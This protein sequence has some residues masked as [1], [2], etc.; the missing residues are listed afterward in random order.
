MTIK[1]NCLLTW[2]LEE[3]KDKNRNEERYRAN[4]KIY[5]ECINQINSLGYSEVPDERYDELM[6][7]IE[8][9]GDK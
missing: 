7:E 9:E 4:L 8:K 2:G 5:K 6:K 1:A 3:E